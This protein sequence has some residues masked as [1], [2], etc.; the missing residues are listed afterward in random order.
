MGALLACGIAAS[1]LHATLIRYDFAGTLNSS[2]Y[3]AGGPLSSTL[4]A[5]SGLLGSA[6]SG[7][8][9]FDIDAPDTDLTPAA[10]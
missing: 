1:P 6:Y 8:A 7:Y 4:L 5:D 9:T 2:P 10:A 3:L